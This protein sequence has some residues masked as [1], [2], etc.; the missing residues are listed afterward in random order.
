MQT[1]EK[2]LLFFLIVN[3]E[4]LFS[5]SQN[6]TFALVVSRT[7]TETRLFFLFSRFHK[8]GS[9]KLRPAVHGELLLPRGIPGRIRDA[10]EREGRR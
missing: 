10:G 9:S 7:T 8:R 4:R 6:A 3:R 1:Y 2:I 5:L